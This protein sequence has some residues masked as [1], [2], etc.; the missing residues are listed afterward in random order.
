MG[1]Q[2]SKVNAQLEDALEVVQN[3]ANEE[4][5]DDIITELEAINSLVEATY[6]YIV[7]TYKATGDGA[8]EIET[9]IYKVGGAGG[10]TVST[11]TLAYNGDDKLSTITKT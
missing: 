4:K 5:Q 11:L 2:T 10:T 7:L 8:G 1:K 9:V 6:D 3:P